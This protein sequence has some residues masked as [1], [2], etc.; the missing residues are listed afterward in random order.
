M[1]A[2]VAWTFFT[3]FLAWFFYMKNPKA[4]ESIMSGAFAQKIFTLLNNKYYVDELYEIIVLT[5]IRKIFQFLAAFDAMIVDGLV[6]LAGWLGKQIGNF[7]GLFDNTVVDGCV[8]GTA[9]SFQTGG[10]GFSFLQSGRIQTIIGTSLI[11]FV[12]VVFTFVLFL[13]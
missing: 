7:V 9:W 2:S 4:R 3:A 10:K 11:L 8:N 5:P 1:I 13:G 12:A 6:N